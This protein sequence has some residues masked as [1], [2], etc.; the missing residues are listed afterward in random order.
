MIIT[1]EKIL[2]KLKAVIDPEIGINIVDLG[3]IYNLDFNEKKIVVTMTLTTPGCPM[4]SSITKWVKEAL[5]QID[6][7]VEASVNLVW[8]PPWTPNDMSDDAK[9][10]MGRL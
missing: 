6:N 2:E 7:D 3:L 5:S 8:Q 4:H 1:E 10:Q 9:R